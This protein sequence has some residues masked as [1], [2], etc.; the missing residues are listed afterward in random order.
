MRNLVALLFLA[1]CGANVAKMPG[2]DFV[3]V[4]YSNSPLG[5][6]NIYNVLEVDLLLLFPSL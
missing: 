5:D 6:L 4:K 2:D 3:G 1:A